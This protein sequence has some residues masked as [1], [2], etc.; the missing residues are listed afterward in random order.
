MLVNIEKL[1]YPRP[2]FDIVKYE[3]A[4]FQYRMVFV[5]SIGKFEGV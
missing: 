5:E 2:V 4:N 1:S 3:N